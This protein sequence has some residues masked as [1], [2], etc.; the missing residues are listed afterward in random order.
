[1]AKILRGL[2][3]REYPVELQSGFSRAGTRTDTPAAREEVAVLARRSRGHVLAPA[4]LLPKDSA[5]P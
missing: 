4:R 2:N 1:M 3:G 5:Q